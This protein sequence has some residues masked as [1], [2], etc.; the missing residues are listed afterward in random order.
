MFSKIYPKLLK[1]L[2]L[3]K[4]IP[5]LQIWSNIRNSIHN[6]GMFVPPKSKAKD[7]DI[8]YDNNTYMFRIGKPVIYGGWKDLCELSYELGKATHQIITSPKIASIPFIEEPGS[9][10]WDLKNMG[11]EELKKIYSEDS[12]K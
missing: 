10:Y 12:K 1:E 2:E 5:L 11:S 4:F 9:K 3:E 8:V 7:E 6:D